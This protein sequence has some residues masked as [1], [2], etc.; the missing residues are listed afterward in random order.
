MQTSVC[1]EETRND[2][3]LF[4]ISLVAYLSDCLPV[5]RSVCLS[6]CLS[7]C[8][9][10]CMFV[11]LLISQIICFALGILFAPISTIPPS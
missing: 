2:F 10:V 11:C 1:K 5:C 6:I 7:V 4:L 3:Q 8:S 9:S